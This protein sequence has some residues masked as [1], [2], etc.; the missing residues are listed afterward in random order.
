MQNYT[1]DLLLRIENY[2]IYLFIDSL[3]L[4]FWVG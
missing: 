3:R 4:L 2:Y 1:Y